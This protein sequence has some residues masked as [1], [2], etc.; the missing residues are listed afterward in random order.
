MVPLFLPQLWIS[1]ARTMLPDG[2]AVANAR[3]A[4]ERDRLAAR[5]RVDAEA[6]LPAVLP[7][8]SP[9]GRADPQ[10]PSRAV[11]RC[12]RSASSS[13]SQISLTVG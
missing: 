6:A 3:A 4:V 2:R 7:S 10:P 1:I 9:L 12:P 11:P 8:G 5:A 13:R